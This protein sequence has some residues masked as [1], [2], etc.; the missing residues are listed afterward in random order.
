MDVFLFPRLS[1]SATDIHQL[2]FLLG[3]ETVH[4][5]FG[6]AGGKKREKKKKKN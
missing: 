1:N 3:H 2:S 6:H 4:S 5:V